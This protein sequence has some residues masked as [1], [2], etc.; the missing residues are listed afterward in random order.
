L[1]ESIDKKPLRYPIQDVYIVGD[2]RIFVGRVESG[3]IEVDEE[4]TVLPNP[5]K[6]K[7]KSIEVYGKDTK[8]AKSGE[9]IGVTTRDKLFIERG[10][11]ICSGRAPNVSDSFK[12]KVFWMDK[13]PLKEGEKL[14]LKLATQ[15]V[16]CTLTIER[17]IDS[18]TL[19]TLTPSELANNEVAEA[20][21]KT[22]QPTVVENFNDIPELGRFTLTRDQ[23]TVA[24]G[25]IV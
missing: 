18:S 22:D 21:I 23:D 6:T 11:V 9:S 7:I 25:I 12:A 16:G 1:A 20:T 19:D 14:T 2:K 5:R 10:N 13:K 24:G 17:R 8:D 3:K 4:V 15:E